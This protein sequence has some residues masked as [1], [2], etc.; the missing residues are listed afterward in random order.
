MANCDV[1]FDARGNRTQS[2]INGATGSFSYDR[3]NRIVAQTQ[4]GVTT[5]FDLDAADCRSA[6]TV[7]SVE[8]QY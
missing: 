1:Q 8:T 7:G 5:Q 6:Q 2:V 3:M 4:T